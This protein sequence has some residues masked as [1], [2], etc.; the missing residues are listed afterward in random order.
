M[1]DAPSDS[2]ARPPPNTRNAGVGQVDDAAFVTG[3]VHEVDGG[4]VQ[5]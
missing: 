1:H 5:L 3:S 4:Q 2:P